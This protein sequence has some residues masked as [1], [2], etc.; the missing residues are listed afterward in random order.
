MRYTIHGFLNEADGHFFDG[1]DIAADQRVVF[2]GTI[3]VDAPDE[4]SALDMAYVVGNRMA[5]DANGTAW[6][7]FSRSISVGDVLVAE[8]HADLSHAAA[9]AVGSFGFTALP[10]DLKLNFGPY[11]YPIARL[12]SRIESEAVSA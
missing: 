3:V 1:Y 8:P 6:P 9:W 5:R 7:C 4:A 2:G 12:S 10:D 11:K